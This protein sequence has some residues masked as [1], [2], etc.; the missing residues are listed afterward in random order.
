VEFQFDDTIYNVSGSRECEPHV[1][2]SM[3]YSSKCCRLINGGALVNGLPYPAPP[4]SG[5]LGGVPFVNAGWDSVVFV[6]T[7][8]FTIRSY[9]AYLTGKFVEE[10]ED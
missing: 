5:T 2:D 7:G 4:A 10:E 3:R 1:G 6:G 8:P 9:G